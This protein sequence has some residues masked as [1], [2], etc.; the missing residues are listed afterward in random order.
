M[1]LQRWLNLLTRSIL[2]TPLLN[3]TIANRILVIIVEGRKTGR[4]YTIPVGYTPSPWGLLV[5]TAGT[6]RRNLIDAKPVDIIVNR[7]RTTADAEVI[8]DEKRCAERY[9]LILKHNPVHGRY[10]GIRTDPEGNPILD[11]LRAALTRGAA[12]VQLT[13]HD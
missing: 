7:T 1:R 12:V 8:T 9:R 10:A 6:W 11:D 4:R 2:A 13:P 3:R 5:G